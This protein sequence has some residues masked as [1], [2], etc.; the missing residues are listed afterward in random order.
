MSSNT[1]DHTSIAVDA[2]RFAFDLDFERRIPFL[3]DIFYLM[4]RSEEAKV[5]SLLSHGFVQVVLD[6]LFEVEF[7]GTTIAQLKSLRDGDESDAL[8]VSLLASLTSVPFH[9]SYLGIP[10]LGHR[11]IQ[12]LPCRHQVFTR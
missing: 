5:L 4:I 6:M 3:E 7:V 8:S 2:L 9:E 12:N 1:V 10:C 11:P